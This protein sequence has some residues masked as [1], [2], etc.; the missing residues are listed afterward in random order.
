MTRQTR[1]LAAIMFTDIQGY[2]ALMQKDEKLAVSI[3]EKHREVFKNLTEKFHGK[4]L[5]YYG[6]GTLSIFDSAIDAVNCGMEMQLELQQQPAIPVRIGIHTGDI[7]FS[8]EEIIGDGVNIASR[9]ES[10]AV[11]GSVFV[12]DKVY[13]EIKNHST[14]QTQPLRSFEFK[15]VEKPIEVYAI[16]NKGLVIPKISKL[17]G[18]IQQ[19]FTNT[20]HSESLTRKS[21]N[22]IRWVVGIAI[23][24]VLSIGSVFL[25]QNKKVESIRSIGVL[26]FE[27]ISEGSKQDYFS[28]GMT[29]ALIAELSKIGALRV[30]SR[31]SIMRYKDTQKSVPEIANELKIDAIV[32]GSVIRAGNK[33]RVVA[34]LVGAF[35]ERHIWAQT[36]DRDLNDV[37]SL[38]SEVAEAIAD[39]IKIAITPEEKKRI[40]DR[41]KV[42]PKA[43]ESYLRGKHHANNK[44]EHGLLTSL[45]YLQSAIELD[46]TFADAYAWLAYTYVEIGNFGIQSSKDTYPK[47][48]KAA[49]K[50][51][52]LDNNLDVAHAAIGRVKMVYDLDWNSAERAFKKALEINSNSNLNME[53]YADYLF[54]TGKYDESLDLL[55]RSIAIDPF[56]TSSIL[57]LGQFYLLNEHYDL[58]IE[59]INKVIELNPNIF[60][61][62]IFLG[63]AYTGKGM[64]EEGKAYINKAINLAGGSNYFTSL[65]LGLIYL[66]SGDKEKALHAVRELESMAEQNSVITI[67]I[68]VIYAG[69]D[70]KD[71]ALLWIE[72]SY[73][74]RSNSLFLLN[75]FREFDHLK[76]DPDFI[77]LQRKIG[78]AAPFN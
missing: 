7:L 31:T 12:S 48:L 13:D 2:T 42:N 69:L 51:L 5:Q 55:I 33:I 34:Q 11:P 63:N 6:D 22:W 71:E 70:K 15:N 37:L 36:Y 76:S 57:H 60:L 43:L 38:Y 73:E 45:K 10:I 23:I 35:P 27:D 1:Q 67:W 8:D 61:A 39:E 4:I 58:A 72:K 24:A 66:E 26:P 14:I 30:I 9:I 20:K 46:P 25:F 62:Y 74:D 68:A 28:D 18:G 78:L 3:R 21:K 56:S 77:R 53:W 65:S 47:A 52:T 29:E 64:V 50:A 44:S 19:S 49:E 16:S 41:S 59:E 40:M 75:T 54:A 17:E 32:E